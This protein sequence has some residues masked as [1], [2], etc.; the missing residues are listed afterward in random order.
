[1]QILNR[2][3]REKI[4]LG[5]FQGKR[6]PCD[7]A[8]TVFRTAPAGP[9]A[10]E[11][12]LLDGEEGDSIVFLNAPP[13]ERAFASDVELSLEETESLWREMAEYTDMNEAMY[14]RLLEAER[15]ARAED[16]RGIPED[17][18]VPVGYTVR[19][20]RIWRERSDGED[21]KTEQ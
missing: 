12:Y 13:P 20:R 16:F 3:R 2:T 21:A 14:G 9:A 7:K 19:L 1:V 10:F 15:L 17:M 5:W 6:I 11:W 8:S 18:G 4:D